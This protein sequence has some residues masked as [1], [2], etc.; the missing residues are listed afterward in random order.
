L[1]TVCRSAVSIAI[2]SSANVHDERENI[3][4]ALLDIA[5]VS[6][7]QSIAICLAEQLGCDDVLAATGECFP[8]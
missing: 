6:L 8:L 5:D 4:N 7:A 1:K 3:I 2:V